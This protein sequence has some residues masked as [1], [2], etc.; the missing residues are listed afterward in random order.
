MLVVPWSHC[1]HMFTS[2]GRRERNRERKRK[3][4]NN[5]VM[6]WLCVSPLPFTP[7]TP[8]SV[9]LSGAAP[10]ASH[11]SPF[12][13]CCSPSAAPPHPSPPLSPTSSGCGGFGRS[14]WNKGR[15]KKENPPLPHHLH[16]PSCVA[17]S[18]LQGKK[19][20]PRVCL[21]EKVL[22]GKTSFEL[23]AHELTGSVPSAGEVSRVAKWEK[24]PVWVRR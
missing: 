7:L 23:G 17:P 20:S 12:Q 6:E 18:L 11:A 15:W 14:K 24:P 2:R 13:Y 10:A 5:S 22:P 1:R 9:A 3:W 4:E 19:S 16:P 8:Q 21:I